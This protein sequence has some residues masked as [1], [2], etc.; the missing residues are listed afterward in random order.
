MEFFLD[1][2][3]RYIKE[4][5]D[6]IYRIKKAS[7]RISTLSNEQ[8]KSKTLSFK[9]R[10]EKGESLDEI[11]PEAFAVLSEASS[12][13]L[14]K[15]PRDVQ[16]MGAMAIHDGNVA[17]MKTGEGKTL[18]ATLAAYLNALSGRSV[19]IATSNDYLASRDMEE[20]GKLFNS[21]G[22][23][24]GLVTEKRTGT[25]EEEVEKRKEAYGCD[26]VYGSGNAF[27]F[28]YLRDNTASSIEYV[29][30]T[31]KEVGLMIIDEADQILVNDARMPF[32]L[33]GERKDTDKEEKSKQDAQIA[34]YYRYAND[35]V[36]KLF[37]R[38]KLCKKMDTE[39]EYEDY[40]QKENRNSSLDRNYTVIYRPSYQATLTERGW[41]EVFKYF[42]KSQINNIV[43]KN[44]SII[45]NSTLF[46]EGKD[47]DYYIDENGINLSLRGLA[48]AVS[49]IDEMRGLNNSFYASSEFASIN[50][51]IENALKA[52]FVLERDVDYTL[53]GDSRAIGS[54]VKKKV[55]L[56]SNG[57]TAEGR[58]YSEGLQQAIE[59]K[60]KKMAE[61][62][63][64][65]YVIESTSESETLASISQKSFYSIYPKIA[66]MT[67]T[68]SKELFEL[69]YNMDTIEI[70]KHSSYS[71]SQE[72]KEEIEEG[73]INK[74]TVLFETD[75]EKLAAT[76]A[77]VLKS[78]KNGQPVLIGTLSIEE[79]E[80]L[81]KEFQKR[82]IPCNVLNA[83]NAIEEGQII[84]M[85]GIKGSVTIST[86]MAGRGTDIELGGKKDV[87]IDKIIEEK[88]EE[89]KQKQLVERAS[90]MVDLRLGDLIV[91]A[92]EYNELL[93]SALQYLE[94]K[95]EVIEIGKDK[96]ALIRVQAEVIYKTEYRDPVLASGGLKVIG[97]GH[98]PTKRDDDQLRGRAS[99]QADPGVTEFY[100]SVETDLR[101]HLSVP[102]YKI[103]YLHKK[104]LKEGNPKKGSIVDKVI[105]IAQENNEA[106][107]MQA[108][109]NAQESD[110]Q[111][112]K[113]REGLYEQRKRMLGALDINL[114]MEYMISSSVDH[115]I[116]RNIPSD[117]YG[118][119][120][121]SKVK[122]S[123]LNVHNLIV[124][125]EETFG[126]DLTEH[127]ET[128]KIR[129]LGDIEN[130]VNKFALSQYRNL[131]KT[132][133][134]EVQ[135]ELDRKVL[136]DTV[137]KAWMDF[138]DSVDEIEFQNRMYSL[139]QNKE[140]KE[141][142]VMRREFNYVTSEAKISSLASIFGKKSEKMR[143]SDEELT[144]EVQVEDANDY[145]VTP[146]KIT[147]TN[148]NIRVGKV[149][150]TMVDKVK[151][152]PTFF[153]EQFK[154]TTIS[155]DDDVD[156]VDF[157]DDVP[158]KK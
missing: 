1:D 92:D 104:G 57:R 20:M 72:E 38:K 144:T 8:L 64:A 78:V 58:V 6:M 94:T 59:Y 138:N 43:N 109:C 84:S 48:K 10:L 61:L 141:L 25:Y 114:D 123:S 73:R 126:I 23:T 26:I 74:G 49:E 85:A 143:I 4:Y 98:Y 39:E 51:A 24:V 81:Y 95:N 145:F 101:K 148:L 89:E 137:D 147:F 42:S 17:Q 29:T 46:E 5:E 119:T 116:A 155:L 44:A 153:K 66:G 12:R 112:A 140:Y 149:L 27:A 9:R 124:D 19:H 13:V 69:V 36:G 150:T 82:G 33:S 76:I 122:G 65:N 77:S 115:V 118:Y 151:L 41:L 16:L 32:V 106:Y 105:S 75:K 30:R 99:R 80:E 3:Q 62:S 113:L 133:G 21:L 2:N 130:I 63:N 128:G 139:A 71:V 135:D 100:C 154:L 86:Q 52:Y 11:L 50:K 87:I 136:I 47:K 131:R 117:D 56:V 18:T 28:D 127:F 31:A 146:S 40:M 108:I 35:F 14:G 120:S 129:T 45:T 134:E 103:D 15:R 88:I 102:E 107:L 55:A 121:T 79:S 142:L 90:K 156:S 37:S 53:Q 125:M 68:S 7:K 54:K 93:N 110:R 60:E 22:L 132:N 34:G 83:N 111:I 97:Y 158:K 96:L 70:P 152:V 67:G 157:Q 91:S